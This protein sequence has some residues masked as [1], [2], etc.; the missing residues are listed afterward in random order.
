MP[1]GDAT[2]MATRIAIDGLVAC[3]PFSI[4]VPPIPGTEGA[5]GYKDYKFHARA[6]LKASVFGLVVV[7][8]AAA[9][10]ALSQGGH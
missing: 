5:Q 10:I 2:R 4:V 6:F 9:L 3:I 1:F 8:P 7:V